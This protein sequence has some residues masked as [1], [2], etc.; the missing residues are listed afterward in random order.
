MQV[1]IGFGD[2]I[3]PA[4][5][6]ANLPTLLPL[7]APR[8]R[9]YPLETVVAEKFEAMVRLGRASRRMKDFHDLATLAA[10]R[11]FAGAL[12][13]RAVRAT[14]ARRTTDLALMPDVLTEDFYADP[15][16]GQR[17]RAYLLT[18]SDAARRSITFPEIGQDLR[19]FLVPLAAALAGGP[20]PSAWTSAGGWSP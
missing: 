11:D 14:F 17:W 8:L 12:L 6:E 18:M 16:L 4:P 13:T 7:Q 5:R 20:V 10:R 19:R 3:T 2:A 15:N 9:A 1:D